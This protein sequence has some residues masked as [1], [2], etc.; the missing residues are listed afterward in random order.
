MRWHA[1]CAFI[2][3]PFFFSN[4]EEWFHSLIHPFIPP[5]RLLMHFLSIFSSHSSPRPPSTFYKHPENSIQSKHDQGAYGDG[6]MLK[7]R[8]V[9]GVQWFVWINFFI[10]VPEMKKQNFRNGAEVIHN[11][12]TLPV[13][14][15]KCA[16]KVS[17]YFRAPCDRRRSSLFDWKWEWPVTNGWSIRN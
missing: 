4:S 11:Q 8:I 17:Q 16:G 14:G 6:R 3:F 9:S 7:E 10:M 13:N 15:L 5:Y 1:F 2:S 12:L